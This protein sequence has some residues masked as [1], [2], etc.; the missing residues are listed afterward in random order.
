MSFNPVSLARPTE[1]VISTLSRQALGVSEKTAVGTSNY[2][3]QP[4]EAAGLVL[5]V[6]FW[7][8]ETIIATKMFWRN[9]A[10]A[11][12]VDVGIYAEDGTRLVSI[13]TTVVSGANLVQTV[14]I[15]DTTLARGRYYMA[16]VCSTVTTLTVGVVNIFPPVPAAF[17]MLEQA[18]VT[19]PLSTG[20]SPATF[21]KSVTR[22]NLP[23]VGIHAYRSLGP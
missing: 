7:V 1:V 12:N 6:P 8:A 5:F 14:D 17:G 9:G 22:A 13:G 4:W 19:L 16:M 15:T 21:A 20:A 23:F 18:G 10:V 11:G 2:S 3:Q